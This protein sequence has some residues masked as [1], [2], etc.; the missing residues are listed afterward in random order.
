MVNFVTWLQEGASNKRI[1][2]DAERQPDAAT[3]EV[4]DR[5]LAPASENEEA[6]AKFQKATEKLL[7]IQTLY[8]NMFGKVDH[9][10]LLCIASLLGDLE[11]V[12]K[13]MDNPK[14]DISLDPK[15]V[16]GDIE[17]HPLVL[18]YRQP[19]EA[20]RDKLNEGKLVRKEGGIEMRVKFKP[21]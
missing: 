9:D 15:W 21:L 14:I 13:I 16:A 4:A 11:L 5:P 12:T 17:Q 19:N 10:S 2:N 18:A 7:E 20:V 8:R 3:D 1:P 6:M